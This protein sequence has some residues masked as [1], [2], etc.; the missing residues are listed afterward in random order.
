MRTQHTLHLCGYLQQAV[1]AHC[2]VARPVAFV[3]GP[4]PEAVAPLFN[5]VEALGVPNVR[6]QPHVLPLPPV[7]LQQQIP[8]PA[9]GLAAPALCLLLLLRAGLEALLPLEGGRKGTE[10]SLSMSEES[11]KP[12]A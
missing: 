4:L 11:D 6:L 3:R 7:E 2:P 1:A 9:A 12:D 8:V 10:M 5:H